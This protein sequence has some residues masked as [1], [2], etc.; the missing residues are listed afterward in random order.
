[1]II[2][3]LLV[4]FWILAAIRGLRRGFVIALFSVVG[5]IVGIAAAMALSAT[6][7]QQ[8]STSGNLHAKWLPV[9]SFLLVFFAVAV[10]ISL[11]ARM[12]S[13]VMDIA[14]LGWVNRIAGAAIYILLVSIILSV[15]LFYLTALH[16][17]PAATNGKSVIYP[18]IKPIAPVIVDKLGEFIPLFRN[19][20]GELRNFFE[21]AAN[22]LN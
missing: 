5:F 18:V 21:N 20:F 4:T 19:L 6:V 11:V 22:N 16:I 17:I 7:A 8:I 14:M 9:I 12:I 3:L 15:L 2:D 13:R 10:L 1:M